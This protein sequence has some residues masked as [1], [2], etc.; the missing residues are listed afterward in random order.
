MR[1]YG[2]GEK[3]MKQKQ[4]EEQLNN[5]FK[6]FQ[7]GDFTIKSGTLGDF[8]IGV[9]ESLGDEYSEICLYNEVLTDS[10]V[11]TV[12]LTPQKV[13]VKTFTESGT[14]IESASW[15]DIVKKANK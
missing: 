4:M 14:S 9:C 2:I 6:M 11:T 10:I 1:R 12:A 3:N 8:K 13:Y 7:S 15:A 5:I